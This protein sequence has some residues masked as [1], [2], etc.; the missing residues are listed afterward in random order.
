MAT[1]RRPKS[2]NL[3]AFTLIEVLVVVAIIALLVAILLPSL[4]RAREQARSTQCL[5]QLKQMGNAMVMYTGDNKSSLPG[6]THMLL[7][8]KSYDYFALHGD[9][10]VKWFRQNLPYYLARYLGD[11]Q[12]HNV[13]KVSTC[14]TAEGL[15][16]APIT[17]SAW[18]ITSS[19]YICN[20]GVTVVL[21]PDGTGGAGANDKYMGSGTRE[22]PYYATKTNNYFGY[23][24][25]GG[26]L[27]DYKDVK[28]R[29][30]YAPKKIDKVGIAS[31]EWAIAD[32]WYWKTTGRTPRGTI[33]NAGTWP[34]DP[35]ESVYNGS[36]LTIPSY[37]YHQATS[38]YGSDVNN[39]GADLWGSARLSGGRTN[40]VYMDGHGE[41]VRQWIGT[42]N[43][44]IANEPCQ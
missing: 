44:C 20:T 10:G 36:A 11:K 28:E 35:S 17:S 42:N 6:P 31:R 41:S 25:L 39:A 8:R 12:A 1:R 2:S 18:Y 21:K 19:H 15:K 9:S 34:F 30:R 13:D 40:Q 23:L 43:P 24:N 32:L 26:D 33:R 5:T 37:P 22:Y 3:R 27:Q 4:A 16:V 38:S 29:A 7:Y 14:P